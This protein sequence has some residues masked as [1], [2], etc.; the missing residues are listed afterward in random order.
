M[1]VELARSQGFPEMSRDLGGREQVVGQAAQRRKL[2]QEDDRDDQA[3]APELLY[4]QMNSTSS[5]VADLGRPSA[6]KPRFVSANS[7]RCTSTSD[8][9][10]TVT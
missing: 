5:L 3:P 10:S 8:E 4:S 6:M 2:P 7:S 9:P 1:L